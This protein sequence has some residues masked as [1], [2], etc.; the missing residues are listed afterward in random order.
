MKFG[1]LVLLLLLVNQCGNKIPSDWTFLE[2]MRIR[3]AG[4][5]DHCSSQHCSDPHRLCA[6]SVSW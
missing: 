5:T 1:N 6:I 4:Q 3:C 2:D